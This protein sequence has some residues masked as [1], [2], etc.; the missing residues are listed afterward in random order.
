MTKVV[1]SGTFDP[2][3]LGHLSVIR[4]ASLL[5]DKIIIAVAIASEKKT[6]F[7][8]TRRVNMI[9]AS[10]EHFKNIEVCAFSGLLIDF[11]KE[12]EC[13]CVIRGIRSVVD[14][15]YEL[16]MAAVNQKLQPGTETIF[17]AAEENVSSSLVRQVLSLGGDVS[18]LIPENAL[19]IIKNS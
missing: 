6:Q 1:F 15:S 14:L 3:T 17:F 12:V 8:I 2:I 4:R 19:A 5:F 13:Q 7:D 9:K 16:E 11:L 10:T 18:A